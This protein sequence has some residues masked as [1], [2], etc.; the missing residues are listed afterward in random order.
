MSADIFSEFYV[1]ARDGRINGVHGV[2]S[3]NRRPFMNF[4]LNVRGTRP[5]GLGHTAV[6]PHS[7]FYEVVKNGV[8]LSKTFI[9]QKQRW[10]S[11]LFTLGF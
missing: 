10:S 2:N 9:Q 11:Q 5:Q 7:D 4:R 1:P 3:V 8:N 6:C